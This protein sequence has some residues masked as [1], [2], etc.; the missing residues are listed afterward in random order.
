M[1]VNY[2]D[3]RVSSDGQLKKPHCSS[4]RCVLVIFFW[5]LATWWG[6]PPVQVSSAATNVMLPHQPWCC[7]RQTL[8]ESSQLF[9]DKLLS[10]P[11]SPVVKGRQCFWGSEKKKAYNIKSKVS[12]PSPC[13]LLLNSMHISGWWWGCKEEAQNACTGKVLQAGAFFKS[14]RIIIPFVHFVPPVSVLVIR[15]CGAMLKSGLAVS[16]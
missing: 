4:H 10:K 16:C 2:N 13:L 3:Y 15:R 1:D 12:L 9:L 6:I 7:C 5:E 11:L 14:N 8:T